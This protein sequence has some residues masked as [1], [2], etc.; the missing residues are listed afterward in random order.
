MP[1]SVPKHIFRR[2][3]VSG[4]VSGI[5]AAM[6]ELYPTY[7]ILLGA[8][9]L[10]FQLSQL[11]TAMVVGGSN[12]LRPPQDLAFCSSKSFNWVGCP[13]QGRI[14]WGSRMA[15][16]PT[17]QDSSS[18]L[19]P[20]KNTIYTNNTKSEIQRWKDPISKITCRIRDVRVYAPPPSRPKT[21]K[22]S[23]DAQDMVLR[24]VSPRT[25][26]PDATAILEEARVVLSNGAQCMAVAACR[27][28]SDT[29]LTRGP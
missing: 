2:R 19:Y 12:G 3:R 29:S 28:S 18:L 4:A 9:Q 21:E 6:L 1:R 15:R 24:S 17:L 22:A 13:N 20:T 10:L 16:V 25:T 7:L 11:A 27:C 14:R 5:D 23:T 26:I 8:A